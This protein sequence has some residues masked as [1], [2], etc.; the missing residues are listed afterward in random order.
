VWS[1]ILDYQIKGISVEELSAKEGLLLWCQKKTAGYKDVKVENFTTSWQDGLALCALIHHHRPD[2]IDFDSLSKE[3]KHHNLKLAFE[4]AEKELG[5]AQLLDVPD[6]A[7]V[8]R[9]DERSV[10]TYISEFFHAFSSQNLK[11]IAAKRVQKF[12]QFSRQIENLQA[13]YE[14]QAQ[15]LI[16][17]IQGTIDQFA[18]RSFGNSYDQAKQHFEE[19]KNYLTTEKPNRS[20]IKLDL[21]ALFV[22]IQTNLKTKGR[23]AYAVPS[24]LSTNDIDALWSQ[25]EQAE[26]ARGS[27]LR[28]N[29]FS[30]VSD[31]KASL[32]D[33]QLREFQDTFKHF[34]H[35]GDGL[36]DRLEFK[37][38][39]ASLSIPF[40]DDAAYEQVFKSVSGGANG[41]NFQQFVDYMTDIVADRD[42]PE[43]IKAAFRTL[44]NNN[45]AISSAD[46]RVP[47]LKNDEVEFL[48]GKMSVAH[49]KYYDYVA[50]TDKAF[51]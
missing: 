15:D 26:N 45:D 2:L 48:I 34:D 43:S 9:P 31:T 16:E 49:D 42:T 37:A 3:N 25:L 27:A 51:Q 1:I 41:I 4:V 23:S 8:A 20:A 46:L 40:K 36:L 22:N 19:H 44:A 10:M 33:T 12:V 24:G 6:V 50:F 39:L 32:S 13:E 29:M 17:W 28:G 11:E 18:G 7:D 30:Y 38:C 47:P 14:H 21:E 5:I 35:D